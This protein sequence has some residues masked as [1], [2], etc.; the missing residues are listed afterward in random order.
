MKRSKMLIAI[1]IISVVSYFAKVIFVRD[2]FE[3]NKIDI[4]I[5]V[6]L[7]PIAYFLWKIDEKNRN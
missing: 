3:L 2:K 4:L 1:T 5:M 6:G 7:I